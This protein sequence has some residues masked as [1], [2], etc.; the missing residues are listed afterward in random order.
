MANKLNSMDIKQIIRLHQSGESNRQIAKL[1]GISRNTVN[2]YVRQLGTMDKD[3]GEL[4][5]LE[6]SVFQELFTIKSGVD[7]GRYAALMS[8][9]EQTTMDTG[10]VG[11]TFYHH[12]MQYRDEVSEPYGYT[13]F[14]EH[15]HRKHDRH[16]GSMKLNHPPGR[17]LFIDYTGKKLSYIDKDTGEHIEVE[18]LVAILPYSQYTYV[19]ATASQSKEDLIECVQSALRYYGG[20][21]KAIVSD[22]LKSAVSRSHKHEAVINKTFK[23][24]AQH[25]GCVVNPTRSYSPQDKALVEGAVKLVY[26]QIYYRMRQMTFF[27]LEEINTEIRRQLESYNARMFQQKKASRTELFQS[28]E[29]STL[30]PLPQQS[31][32][33]KHYKRAKVQKMGYVYLSNDKCYYSV[34]YR[35]IG[36]QVQ[37]AYSKGQVEVFYAHQRIAIHQRPPGSQGQYFTIKEHL[38]STHQHYLEWSPEYFEKKASSYGEDVQRLV[39]LMFSLHKGYPEHYY[40]RINGIFSLAKAYGK[41]RLNAACRRAIQGQLYSYHAIENILKKGLD[42][43]SYINEQE[44]EPHIKPHDHIRGSNYYQ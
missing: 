43:L 18:V 24:F 33:I 36:R 19:Q 35:Y 8:Y 14:M 32:Q 2:D 4:L 26:Q 3:L 17:E 34:P 37:L 44:T 1:L 30:S 25:Y 9:F 40:K 22:N 31:Y 13:Q 28:V 41:D 6:E 15:Y 23:D 20:S 29:K 39:T 42:Q 38:A 11:F 16:K 10:Q 12:Y 7:Q 27:S 21:P 5:R